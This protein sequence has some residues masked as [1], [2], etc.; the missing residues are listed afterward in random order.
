MNSWV[1]LQAPSFDAV[2]TWR[3]QQEE[4][5]KQRVGNA[6]NIMS[7]ED[8]LIFIQYYQRLTQHALCTLGNHA[9]F[10]FELDNARNITKSRH[11]AK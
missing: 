4:K 10:I 3:M 1:F 9:D 11:N 2:Y 7:D 6:S 8:I 5:L